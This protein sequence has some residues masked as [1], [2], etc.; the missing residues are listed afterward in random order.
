M[1]KQSKI[2]QFQTCLE[3]AKRMQHHLEFKPDE[4]PMRVRSYRLAA[5][6]LEQHG[7][8]DGISDVKYIGKGMLAHFDEIIRTGSSQLLES[9]SSYGPPYETRELTQ[10][11][12]IG[13]KGA[14]K[15]YEEYGATSMASLKQK[16]NMGEVTDAKI[17]QAFFDFTANSA[18]IPRGLVTS[19]IQP[20]LDACLDVKTISEA[21]LAGS[22]RRWRPDVRDI[23]VLMRIKS[24]DNVQSAV[25]AISKAIGAPVTAD[26]DRKAYLKLKVGGSERKLDLNFIESDSWGTAVLHFTGSGKF[27]TAFRTHAQ[28]E[29]GAKVSQYYVDQGRKRYYFDIEEDVFDFFELPFT[30]PECRD[31]HLNVTEPVDVVYESDIVGDLHSHTVDSDGSAT[32]EELLASA[33]KQGYKFFGVSN[34]SKSTGGGLKQDEAVKLARRIRKMRNAERTSGS[35]FRPYASVELDIKA[36]GTLDYDP[37]VL[38]EFDYIVLAMHSKPE[39]NTYERLAGA[40]RQIGPRPIIF[41]HPTARIIGFRSEIQADWHEIFKLCRMHNVIVEI[42]GQPDRCDTPDHLIVRSYNRAKNIRTL[43]AVNSDCH[44]SDPWGTQINGVHVAMRGLLRKSDVINT[45]HSKF[46]AWLDSFQK[47]KV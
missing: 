5:E 17:I 32:V 44:S 26:G 22:Y 40:L 14:L 41:A 15:L 18:R 42:N 37:S 8:L 36:D 23:D 25:R 19:S 7:T 39:H 38:H 43:F 2:T 46:R 3:F 33:K 34:H 11:P 30:P 20:I 1:A 28:A 13:P 16:I 9:V 12:G 6:A 35:E 47:D 24:Y 27:N 21:I 4:N 45:S 31:Y 29:F 10:L